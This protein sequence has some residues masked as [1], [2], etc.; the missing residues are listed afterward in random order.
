MLT[1]HGSDLLENAGAYS[2]ASTI[3]FFIVNSMK[4]T[5]LFL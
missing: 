5:F 1:S 3:V 2:P 4:F